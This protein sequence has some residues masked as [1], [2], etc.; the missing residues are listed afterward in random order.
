MPYITQLKW[1]YY[2]VFQYYIRV[3]AVRAGLDRG[4]EKVIIAGKLAF[5]LQKKKG[6][7]T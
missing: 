3:V 1:R 7:Q 6:S 4:D 2:V 5:H